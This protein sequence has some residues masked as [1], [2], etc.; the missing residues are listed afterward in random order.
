MRKHK[1]AMVPFHSVVLSQ[2]L[3]QIM[4]KRPRLAWTIADAWSR[5]LSTTHPMAPLRPFFP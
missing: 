1:E 3:K 5:R 2:Q 4:E